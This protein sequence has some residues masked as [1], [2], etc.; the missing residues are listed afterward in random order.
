MGCSV[1]KTEKENNTVL[2]KCDRFGFKPSDPRVQLAT[3]TNTHFVFL[4]TVHKHGM[5]T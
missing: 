3:D 1:L 2:F 5:D 4:N